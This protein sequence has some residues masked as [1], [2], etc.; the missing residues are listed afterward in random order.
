MFHPS[1]GHEEPTSNYAD[2]RPF[3][4]RHPNLLWIALGMAVI[5]L[6]YAALRA[7]STPSPAD[8]EK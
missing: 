5:L 2:A 6:G 4:E 7:F 1:L 3:T 8:G